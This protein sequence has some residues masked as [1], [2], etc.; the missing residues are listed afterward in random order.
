MAIIRSMT[1]KERRVP[2]ILNASR[3]KRIAAGSGTTVQQVN[4]LIRQ[5]EQ[6]SEMMKKFSKMT[7]GKKGLGKMPGLG[8]GM[9]G[10][11]GMG[12][13]PFGKGKFPF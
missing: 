13:N 4:Q 8:K 5:F 7:K 3:R 9:G 12:G 6:T 11:P 2:N 1:K 10:F